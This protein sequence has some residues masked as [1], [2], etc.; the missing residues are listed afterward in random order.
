MGLEVSRLARNSADWHRLIELCAMAGTLILDQDGTYDP[1]CF[2]DRL[3]LGLKGTM[4]EAELHI[5]KA[6]MRGGV[7][8]KARRGELEMMP[9]V[10]LAYQDNGVLG[11]DPDASIQAALRLV[12]D[13]FERTGSAFQSVRKMVEDG[14]RFPCRQRVGEKK[15][16]LTWAV[17]SHSRVL[18][19]LRNP[20]YAGAFVYGRTR[21]R[22]QPNGRINQKKLPVAQWQFVF[23]QSHVGY[24]TWEQ[25]LANQQ[26]LTD[27]SMA[28][29]KQR[30]SGPVRE[31]PALLQGR[32]L[33]GICG[34]HMTMQYNHVREK[35]LPI[36]MCQEDAVRRG[37]S[38]CQQIRGVALDQAI[39]ALLL[40]LMTP[41]TVD[42]ALAVQEEIEARI[43]ETD[44]LRRV[45]LE[46][47]RY[48]AELARRRYMKADPDNRLVVN[49]LEAEW[50]NKLRVHL[51][52]QEEYEQQTEKERR[53]IDTHTR[54]KLRSLAED[55][56]RVWNDPTLEPRE[57][58]RI[59]RLL[60]ED[61]TLIKAEVITAHVR[62]RGGATRTLTVPVGLPAWMIRKTPAAIVSMIDELLDTHSE[63]EITA[64]LNERGHRT[65]RQMPYTLDRVVWLCTTY[66]LKNRRARL[67]ERGF[68]TTEQLR[69]R[70]QV[71]QSTLRRWR[72]AGLLSR[73]YHGNGS[74]C[75]YGPPENIDQ[76]KVKIPRSM[77]A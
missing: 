69:R 43:G 45:Q 44:A 21:A 38:I 15:G 67:L 59:V 47:A 19:V 26:R 6:R 28:F 64:I 73:K 46:R 70:L 1:T 54:Q 52:A 41:M 55:F 61:V 20:R 13:T 29:G 8:N 18:Q 4:S 31:G 48:E 30:S 25:Y 74:R 56:P 11:L 76:L 49:N 42:I 16:D 9:P 71:S 3:V 39:S 50:N 12:F 37:R 57:R 24:I 77:N 7:L 62:L 17:P 5:L 65:Y 63:V 32:V 27:N 51:A 10:G 14:F 72:K 75:L 2:N 34:A 40:E 66:K 60:I 35:L 53:L 58:K 23:P 36:Y 33:C 68:G 22:P